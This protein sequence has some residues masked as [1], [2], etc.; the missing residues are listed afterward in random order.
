ML[1]HSYS[2]Y[3]SILFYMSYSSTLVLEADSFL[4]QWSVC[5]KLHGVLSHKTVWEH[6]TTVFLR[7][8][9]I[10][11]RPVGSLFHSFQHH[12]GGW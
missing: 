2:Q 12:Q 5:T 4:K 3:S 11:Y 7:Y 9:D 1:V 8:L 10:S 6:P